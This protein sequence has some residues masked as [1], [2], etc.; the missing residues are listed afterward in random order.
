MPLL[1]AVTVRR[2]SRGGAQA[3]QIVASPLPSLAVLLTHCGQLIFRKISASGAIGRQI[4]R[5]KCTKF[6]FRWGSVPD[7][8]YGTEMAYYVLMCR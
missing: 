5:L 6:Y 4:L 3:L 8:A 1:L 2:W 7:P